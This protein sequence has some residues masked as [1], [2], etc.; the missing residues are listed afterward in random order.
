MKGKPVAAAKESGK[1]IGRAGEKVGKGLNE[2]VSSKSDREEREKP[3][4]GGSAAL[5]G[6]WLLFAEPLG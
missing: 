3:A 1:G 5:R 2:G 6:W 4:S